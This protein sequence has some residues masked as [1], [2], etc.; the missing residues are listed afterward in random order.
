MDSIDASKGWN[1]IGDL[2]VLPRREA[3]RT[4]STTDMA[5]PSRNVDYYF[6]F[7][8]NVALWSLMST[9]VNVST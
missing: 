2:S 3:T 7:N 1:T 9:E 5:S 8:L 4:Q 6:R